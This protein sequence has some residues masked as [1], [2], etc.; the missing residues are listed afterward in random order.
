MPFYDLRNDNTN[1]PLQ[2]NVKVTDILIRGGGGTITFSDGVNVEYVFDFKKDLS[3]PSGGIFGITLQ[4]D[5][6]QKVYQGILSQALCDTIDWLLQCSSVN[7]RLSIL[8]AKIG[9]ARELSFS[10]ADWL[11]GNPNEIHVIQTG[12]P[13]S[14]EIGPHELSIGGAYHISV[15]RNDTTPVIVGVDIEFKINLITGTIIIRKSGLAQP[16]DGRVIVSS[17]S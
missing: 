12:V 11:A 7:R 5:R 9:L 6:A 14:G 17:T 13:D 4:G 2:A 1:R 16:F 3:V 10:V 15:F 8:E